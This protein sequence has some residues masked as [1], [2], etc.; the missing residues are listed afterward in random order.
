MLDSLT[1]ECR[2]AWEVGAHRAASR[3]NDEVQACYL[4]ALW[5]FDPG[6]REAV[7][8]LN[9]L[10]RERLKFLRMAIKKGDDDA[11]LQQAE[12]AAKFNPTSFEA[13]FA[14]ARLSA[15]A[16]PQRSAESFRMCADLK[17]SDAYYRYRYGLA[18]MQSGRL[19]DAI[20]ALRGVLEGVEDMT[21]PIANAALAE[22]AGLSRMIFERAMLAVRAGR[23][24]EART[25]YLAATGPVTGAGLP[26]GACAM[27]W[28][29]L[30][31]AQIRVALR[32]I[33]EGAKKIWKRTKTRSARLRRGFLAQRAAS[34]ARLAR[35]GARAGD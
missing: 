20:E 6:S 7:D 11:A 32:S 33:G 13:W 28:A 14:I 3:K 29:G 27:F 21:D 1:R 25:L 30:L 15:I 19:E 10:S 4:R 31:A 24:D 8:R 16:D 12:V 22:I 35:H 9:A 18:L 5:S 26:T 17:P 2:K 34:A 23:V